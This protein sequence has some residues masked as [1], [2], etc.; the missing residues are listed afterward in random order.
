MLT[1][2]ICFD[3]KERAGPI[4]KMASMAKYETRSPDNEKAKKY[5]R[6]LR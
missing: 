4:H 3:K 2:T 5:D 6:Q 1:S